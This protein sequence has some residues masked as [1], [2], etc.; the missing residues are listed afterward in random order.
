MGR[1]APHFVRA[2][3][4]TIPCCDRVAAGTAVAAQSPS[5]AA[6]PAATRAALM[7]IPT[8][9]PTMPRAAFST[10]LYRYLF[11][12][13]L[14]RDAG[15]GDAWERAAA[16]RYNSAQSRWLPTYMR[17]WAIGGVLLLGGSAVFEFVLSWRVPSA[18]F[19]VLSLLT[20]SFNG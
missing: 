13:W 17:R 3:R 4:E 15:H 7:R 14:F 19:Y 6:L 16:W 5:G 1:E 10:Q 9:V 11:Y 12:D 20:V 2:V 18:L 8:K